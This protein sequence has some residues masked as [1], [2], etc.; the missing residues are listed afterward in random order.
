M[1][2]CY[3]IDGYKNYNEALNL[4]IDFVQSPSYTKQSINKEKGI[5]L[6]EYKATLDS[7]NNKITKQVKKNLYNVA[8]TKEILGNITSISNMK[9][10]D[11]NLAYNTFYHPSNMTL[12][13]IGDVNIDETVKLV[14]YNQN[15]KTFSKKP[16]VEKA[17]K[18]FLYPLFLII[19]NFRPLSS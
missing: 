9:I 5:I 4:L 1:S 7:P 16:N 17:A 2:A 19:T 14:A 3:F 15:K 6:Q 8:F 11:I 18:Y 10:D 13:I 12:C